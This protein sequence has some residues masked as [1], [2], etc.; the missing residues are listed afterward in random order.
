MP[1]R[2]RTFYQALAT[3]PESILEIVEELAAQGQIESTQE[4]RASLSD[5]ARL[6][7]APRIFRVLDVRTGEWVEI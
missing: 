5:F 4:E 2:K 1:S 3:C 6:C 7:L